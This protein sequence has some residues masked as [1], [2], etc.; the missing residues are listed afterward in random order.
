MFQPPRSAKIRPEH[1]DRQALIY[2]RQSTP[3][4]VRDTIASAARQ[5]DLAQSA[6]RLGWSRERIQVIDQDQGHSRASALGR[7]GFQYLMAEVGLG[8]AG[9]V[10]SLEASRLA[11]SCSD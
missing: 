1:L 7:D 8:R 5:Y 4:Q 6:D 11:R 3:M 9:A 2:V 10:L